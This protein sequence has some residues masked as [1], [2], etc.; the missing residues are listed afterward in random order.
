MLG[1][2]TA[3]ATLIL[4]GG[5]AQIGASWAEVAALVHAGTGARV[6]LADNPGICTSRSVPVPGTCAAH[7]ELLVQTLASLSIKGPVHIAGLSLGS[8]IAAEVAAQL[9]DRALS[10][11][12]CAGSCQE[13]GGF[14]LAPLSVL[15][16]LG[17]ALIGRGGLRGRLPELVQPRMLREEPELALQ[18]LEL[19]RLEGGFAKGALWRQLLAASRFRLQPLLPALPAARA[20]VVGTGDRLVPRSNSRRMAA[21]LCC[22][23]HELEGRGHYLALDGASELASI[24]VATI[25]TSAGLP[26][27]E[28][29]RV[30]E[31]GT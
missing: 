23:C 8:M 13:S 17:R 15:R 5:I 22:P 3:P 10:V 19:R 30:A 25:K 12:L 7:A 1:D 28:G 2:A 4:I 31:K 9:G 29:P 6:V 21:L 11:T 16:M 27:K 14:R 26:R 20:V 24:L 18:L